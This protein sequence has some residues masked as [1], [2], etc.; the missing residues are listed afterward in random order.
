[1][2]DQNIAQQEWI[3][4]AS[5]PLEARSRDTLKN[6]IARHGFS[7]PRLNQQTIGQGFQT[8]SPVLDKVIQGWCQFGR[9]MQG[10][11]FPIV[12]ACLVI[13]RSMLDHPITRCTILEQRSANFQFSNGPLSIGNTRKN[14]QNEVSLIG[15]G[16][17]FCGTLCSGTVLVL[18]PRN[19]TALW[20]MPGNR[21]GGGM[22]LRNS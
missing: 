13:F 17:T 12:F 4:F 11:T 3:D 20:S 7:R 15:L 19:S 8:G 16:D 18:V 1:M 9:Q 2:G 14:G 21:T 6:G 10:G 5:R 22:R